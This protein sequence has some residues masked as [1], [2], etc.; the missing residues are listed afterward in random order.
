MFVFK[1]STT[2]Y[3]NNESVVESATVNAESTAESVSE[4][5]TEITTEIIEE[6]GTEVGTSKTTK[7]IEVATY[8]PDGSNVDH[9]VETLPLMGKGMLGIFLVTV[10][11]VASV[12]ILNKLTG[13]KKDNDNNQ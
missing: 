8:A 9:M 6:K 4:N 12:A 2:I 10:I 3:E 11:I 1:D 7:V 5:A 13:K